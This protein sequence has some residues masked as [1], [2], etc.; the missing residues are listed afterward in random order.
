MKKLFLL[1][2]HTQKAGQ[3]KDFIE[4]NFDTT[5]DLQNADIIIV[6]GGDG[7][8]LKMMH[9]VLAQSEKSSATIPT[10]PLYGINCGSIGF[11]MNECEFD[12]LSKLPELL[13]ESIESKLYPLSATAKTID[14]KIHT[15]CAFNEMTLHRESHQTCH[16]KISVDNVVRL[17]KLIGDGLLVATPAGSSAYNFSAGGPIIPLN[18]KALVLTPLNTYSPRR[19]PGAIL[20]EDAKISVT[21]SSPNDRPTSLTADFATLHNV[22]QIHIEVLKQGAISL[23]FHKHHNLDAR[24]LQ[25]QFMVH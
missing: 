9:H 6:L 10:F 23:L 17:Q 16:L 24:V 8:M 21:V 15:L 3:Y 19:W 11:L 7:F 5:L 14:G 4:R 25:Q 2:S 20:D 12:S 13:E 22:E 1:S 18:S